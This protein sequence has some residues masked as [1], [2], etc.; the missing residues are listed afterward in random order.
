MLAATVAAADASAPPMK[1]AQSTN[2]P[3]LPRAQAAA[4]SKPAKPTAS[5]T[6]MNGRTSRGPEQRVQNGLH[7]ESPRGAQPGEAARPAASLGTTR[8]RPLREP[9]DVRAPSAGP[10]HGG[11]CLPGPHFVPGLVQE[12]GALRDGPPRQ[13]EQGSRE[14]HDHCKH[15]PP[16]LKAGK[17]HGSDHG[18][19]VPRDE[20]HLH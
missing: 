4:T 19:D 13:E 3:L 7:K 8:L 18:K 10:A 1:P 12:L 5:H 2:C 11:E 9:D 14:R 17:K 15:T 6:I 20:E 16:A